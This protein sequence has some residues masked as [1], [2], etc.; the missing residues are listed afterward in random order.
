MK[1]DKKDMKSPEGREL[2]WTGQ[3]KG[4][5]MQTMPSMLKDEE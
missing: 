3:P 4:I 1:E 5:S 2:P